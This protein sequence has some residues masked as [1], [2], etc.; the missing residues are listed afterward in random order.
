MIW[1]PENCVFG[2]IIRVKSGPLYHYGVFVSED[3][4]IQFGHSPFYYTGEHKNEEKI[5]LSTDIDVFADGGIVEKGIPDRKEKKQMKAPDEIVLRARAELGNGGYN[6]LHNNCEHFVNRCAFGVSFSA[7]EREVRE[8]WRKRP[9]FDVFITTE[10]NIE[11]TGFFPAERLKEIDRVTAERLKENKIISWNL[12][13]FAIES[14]YG[15]NPEDVKFRKQP[16]GKWVADGLYFAITHTNGAVAVVVS[17]SPCGTDAENIADFYKK[18]EDKNFAESFAKKINCASN[19]PVDL[20][21]CWTAKESLYK[22]SGKGAFMPS[23]I[24]I[25]DGTVLY[26]EQN[27]VLFACSGNS[28]NLAVFRKVENGKAEILSKGEALCR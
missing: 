26:T 24:E 18:C 19:E 14:S 11:K 21:K 4:V 23:E 5:V 3:E 1:K 13:C 10:R 27:G 20:L 22:Q 7:Q 2:D 28:R 12:L 25:A 16:N 8:K 6:I 15:I 9:R 17:D